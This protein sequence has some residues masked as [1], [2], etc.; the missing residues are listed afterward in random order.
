M[1]AGAAPVAQSCRGEAFDA[2]CGREDSLA[3]RISER[4]DR[5]ECSFDAP[6]RRLSHIN[7]KFPSPYRSLQ[8]KRALDFLGRDGHMGSSP[9]ALVRRGRQKGYRFVACNLIGVNVFFYSR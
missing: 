8:C 1:R 4:A 3:G 7:S 9:E 6:R 5:L 2:R